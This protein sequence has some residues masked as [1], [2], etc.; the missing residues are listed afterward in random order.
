LCISC[1]THASDQLLIVH[2]AAEHNRW[3]CETLT[4]CLFVFGLFACVVVLFCS[5][6]EEPGRRVSA[7]NPSHRGHLGCS[8][9][10]AARA[11]PAAVPVPPV[12][13]LHIAVGPV[14]VNRGPAISLPSLM[15]QPCNDGARMHPE[16]HAARPAICVGANP[17]VCIASGLVATKA[18][19]CDN[20]T[21]TCSD[22]AKVD[23]QPPATAM[24]APRSTTARTVLG[25][26]TALLPCN[27]PCHEASR[28]REQTPQGRCEILAPLANGTVCDMEG[29]ASVAC[30][31]QVRCVAAYNHSFD[32]RSRKEAS[33]CIIEVSSES[34]LIAQPE[35]LMRD[36]TR[37]TST[38][39]SQHR[40]RQ[41]TD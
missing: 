28:L 19:A 29:P 16:R 33:W 23:A 13:T 37:S 22:P 41:G 24:R 35:S 30:A 5:A 2:L 4:S 38:Y 3:I 32:A 17:V 6:G 9:G 11:A 15:V 12:H 7:P 36:R 40:P 18:G 25:V 10:A 27:Y 39:K 14:I 1:I 20:A 21:G 8:G 26:G 34:K 31:R